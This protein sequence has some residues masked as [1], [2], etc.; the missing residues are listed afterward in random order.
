MVRRV[1]RA[2]TFAAD[3]VDGVLCEAAVVIA[4]RPV[5]CG[6]LYRKKRLDLVSLLRS[7]TDE[8]L[9]TMVPATPEW[10]VRDVVSHLVGITADLNALR[11]DAASPEDWTAEQVRVRRQ[12]PVDALAEEWERESPTFEE[13]L[14]LL[15]YEIGSHY[16]GDLLQHV[17]DIRHALGMAIL[18]DDTALAV[19]LD[20][21][22]ISFE[23]ELQESA[24]GSVV[25]RLPDEEWTLGSGTVVLT[26]MGNRFE[27]F[28]CLGGRRSQEQIRAMAWKGNL[29]LVLPV[30]S[31]YPLP[32]HP[33]VES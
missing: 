24:L 32:E 2:A 13:G 22:L 15:G 23:E 21:Y 9:H 27:M 28:R 3:G 30:V 29:D 19:A 8:Q 26:L 1:E 17:A 18:E 16:I 14:R 11:F 25:V 5:D 31:R 6:E 10:A 4:E 33:I 20:F 12:S 7:L